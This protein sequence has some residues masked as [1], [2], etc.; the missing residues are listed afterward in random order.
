ME[1]TML[2]IYLGTWCTGTLLN[3]MLFLHI[4]FCITYVWKIKTKKKK[5]EKDV[6]ANMMTTIEQ[7]IFLHK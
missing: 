3:L 1:N 7:C 2:I 6:S 4:V 5:L